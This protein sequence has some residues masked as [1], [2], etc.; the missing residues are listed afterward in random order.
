MSLI[1]CTSDCIYQKD[2]CCNLEHATAGGESSKNGCLHYV[3][4]QGAKYG[5]TTNVSQTSYGETTTS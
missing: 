2:G 1:A 4:K 3:Q 5:G